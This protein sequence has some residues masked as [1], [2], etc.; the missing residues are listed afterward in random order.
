MSVRVSSL[1]LYFRFVAHQRQDL[2]GRRLLWFPVSCL[3]SWSC[4]RQSC[5]VLL[6]YSYLHVVGTVVH[7]SGPCVCMCVCAP[8]LLGRGMLVMCR[9][10]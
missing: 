7:P 3:A 4:T 6:W 5:P 1:I 10:S 9:L 2:C 8:S